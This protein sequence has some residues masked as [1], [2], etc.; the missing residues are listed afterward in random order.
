MSL[1]LRATDIEAMPDFTPEH[2][3]RLM[4]SA[5]LLGEKCGVDGSSYGEFPWVVEL[6]AQPN[7]K[8]VTFCPENFS[9]GTPRD[10]PDITGGN[11]F[12]VLDGKAKVMS[13]KGVDWTEGIVRAAQKMLA[14]AK[15]HDVQVAILQDMSAACGVQVISDGCRLVAERRFQKGPGVCTA[16]LLRN[17]IKVVSE[18]DFRTLDHL[19]CKLDPSHRRDATAIDYHESDWYRAHLG[20][21]RGVA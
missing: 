3:L 6:A 19:R 20:P 7:V 11:G 4:L 16:L 15:H 12:D 13:D 17:G 9:F 1:I 18:R 2:P 5:C 14:L 21:G 10:M 8:A